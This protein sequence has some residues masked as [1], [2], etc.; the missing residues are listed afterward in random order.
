MVDLGDCGWW[1]LCVQ[2][3]NCYTSPKWYVSTSPFS[4]RAGT[5]TLWRLQLVPYRTSVLAIGW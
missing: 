5:S 3:L 2:A 1:V 4:R